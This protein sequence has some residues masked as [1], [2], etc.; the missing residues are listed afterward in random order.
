MTPVRA[1]GVGGVCR[2]AS[3]NAR[4]DSASF[5]I[6]WVSLETGSGPTS[7]NAALVASTTKEM[8]RATTPR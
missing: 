1:S 8:C 7:R 4:R 6:R 3:A 2:Q 5:A